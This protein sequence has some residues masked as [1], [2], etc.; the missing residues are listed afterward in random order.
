MNQ[1][2]KQ[3]WAYEERADPA[4]SAN[5]G[6]SHRHGTSLT[7]CKMSM[8]ATLLIGLMLVFAGCGTYYDPSDDYVRGLRWYDRGRMDLAEQLWLPLVAKDDPDAEFR[9]G[10]MLWNNQRGENRELEAIDLFRKSAQQGQ[11]KALLILAD[12]YYQSPNNPTWQIL[13]PPFPRDIERALSLYFKAERTAYYAQDKAKLS[14]VL[15]KIKAE[16]PPDRIIAIEHEVQQ[17]QPV[18][19]GREPRKLL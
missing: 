12:L 1:A 19:V 6:A 17:W 2:G 10:W 4:A 14:S 15:P 18:I 13:K 7:L 8:R 5:V 3:S 16:V 9:L 11:T